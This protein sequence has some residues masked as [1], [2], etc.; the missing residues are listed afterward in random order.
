[1]KSVGRGATEWEVGLAVPLI[2]LG[3]GR[4]LP[5]VPRPAAPAY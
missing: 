2:G 1:V 5:P 4:L 3:L